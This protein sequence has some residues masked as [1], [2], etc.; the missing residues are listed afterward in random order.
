MAHITAAPTI[1]PLV[2]PL[3]VSWA[4]W[5]QQATD[6]IRKAELI[7]VKFQGSL[8][9]DLIDQVLLI[10]NRSYE[11]TAIRAIHA[12]LGTDSSDVTV[13]VTKDTDTDAPGA[14]TALI[15]TAFNLKAAINTV[16]QGT[17]TATKADRKL[18]AGDRLSVLF[19]GTL[20]NVSGLNVT[21]TLRAI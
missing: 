19:N 9:A 14:G 10:A 12:A 17:L 6:S 15:Q 13:T 21:A 2:W 18:V 1:T 7:Q 4:V 16:Q 5:F 3:P 20:T 8:N 11:L